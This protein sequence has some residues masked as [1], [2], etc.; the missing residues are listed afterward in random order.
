MP[1]SYRASA[2]HT[3]GSG[4]SVRTAPAATRADS[5]CEQPP[6]SAAAID[7]RRRLRPEQR[8]SPVA[9]VDVDVDRSRRRRAHPR[10]SRGTPTRRPRGCR[11]EEPQG[12]GGEG[13]RDDRP[14]SGCGPLEPEPGDS[15]GGGADI[16]AASSTRRAPAWRHTRRR[17]RAGLR[18]GGECLRFSSSSSRSTAS[19][20]SPSSPTRPPWPRSCSP[21][22]TGRCRSSSV[23]PQRSPCRASSP[24]PPVSS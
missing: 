3:T 2:K 16:F 4:T 1:C 7:L 21:R 22:D 14:A 6:A 10:G 12:A 20:S 18:R 11:R 17:R 24:W 5:R 23:R 9:H 13:R 19:S 8:R 15:G